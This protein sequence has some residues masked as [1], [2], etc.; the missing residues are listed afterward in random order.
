MYVYM[1]DLVNCK[2][3]KLAMIYQHVAK[4]KYQLGVK[5]VREM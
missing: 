4:I 3:I 1:C 2:I 5:L